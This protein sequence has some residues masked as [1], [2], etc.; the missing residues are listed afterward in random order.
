MQCEKCNMQLEEGMVFCPGCGNRI[1]NTEEETQKSAPEA[2]N[3]AEEVSGDAKEIT[4]ESAP[5]QEDKAAA[6]VEDTKEDAA[7]GESAE[8]QSIVVQ[9]AVA[10]GTVIETSKIKYCHNCGAANAESDAFCYSCGTP[11]GKENAESGKDK[12]KSGGIW[13][14]AGIKFNKKI[15][16]GIAAGIVVLFAAVLCLALFA[17]KGG[18]KAQLLYL[19]DNELVSFRKNEKVA[20]DDDIYEDRD[21]VYGPYGELRQYVCVSEDGKY[22]FYPQDYEGGSFH[23]YCRKLGDAK[24][25]GRKIA[26]DIT[27][28]TVL[29]NNKVVFQESG[30]NGKLYISDLT[31]KEK[32]ASD[33][34]WYKISGDEKNILWRTSD[35]DNKIYTCDLSLKEEK[36]KLDSEVSSIIYI[37][38]DLKKITYLKD[39][40]LYYIEDF[41]EKTKIDSDIEDYYW[42]K[43]GEQVEIYY[44]VEGSKEFTVSDIVEDDYAQQDA[45]MQEPNIADYQTVETKPSFWG[46][47]EE[48]V[49]DDAYYEDLEKYN[50]KLVRDQ[51]RS[52]MEEET[53]DSEYTIY[54][55]VLGDEDSE[56][57]AEGLVTGV[58]GYGEPVFLYAECDLES[59]EKVKLSKLI[60]MDYS[61]IMEKI[62]R[63]VYDVTKVYMVHKGEKAELYIDFEEYD[64]EWGLDGY[65]GVE[66][67][68]ECYFV[69]RTLDDEDYE[70]NLL[71]TDYGKM[72]G[73]LELVAEG[74]GGIEAI[75]D[76]GVYYIA[77]LDDDAGELYLDDKKI[78]SDVRTGSILE[79]GNGAGVLYLTD[80]DDREG[81]LRMYTGSESVK[82]ADDVAAYQSNE[83]G[84]TAFLADYNFKRYRGELKI[85]KDKK[86]VSVDSD[87]TCILYY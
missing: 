14:K 80:A 65:T 81:T 32:I 20:L 49:T 73:K 58:S 1:V 7:E 70:L 11:F 50:E 15:A 68:K 74:V 46:M 86:T 53:L 79:L 71:K 16:A 66:G 69:L 63:A 26:S 5:E 22:V 25:E 56:K 85:Y 61:E 23:L 31:D 48:T 30:N 54:R 38:D 21:S 10:P 42:V 72:D 47:R 84:E 76:K 8:V 82:I 67:T 77:E 87:V 2:E 40:S 29:K 83:K 51:F 52:G 6:E 13:E 39:D 24:D 3:A 34:S 27:R 41:G 4:E 37:S 75:T 44:S 60:E 45:A 9:N 78:D 57:Y 59:V 33:V 17:G 62:S 28:Y 36:N 18:K 64:L 19:K 43:S 55:Y 12:N 35:G